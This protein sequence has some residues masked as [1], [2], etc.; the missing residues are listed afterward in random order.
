MLN[1]NMAL[2]ALVAVKLAT[3]NF[4]CNVLRDT[5]EAEKFDVNELLEASARVELGTRGCNFKFP[6]LGGSLEA[7]LEVKICNV[8]EPLAAGKFGV[9]NFHRDVLGSMTGNSW[10]CPTTRNKI[11]KMITVAFHLLRWDMPCFLGTV[12]S[13]LCTWMQCRHKG[14]VCCVASR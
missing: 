3:G 8:L 7:E 4:H 5:F 9:R 11:K 2:L 10:N 12:V 6:T 1:K 13:G 14:V